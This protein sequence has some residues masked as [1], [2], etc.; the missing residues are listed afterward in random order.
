MKP[1][2]L[3]P[4]DLAHAP[5]PA[6]RHEHALL[7]VVERGRQASVQHRQD[8]ARRVRTLPDR[9]LGRGRPSASPCPGSTIDRAITQRP[10]PFE[11]GHGERRVEAGQPSASSAPSTPASNPVQVRGVAHC[12]DHRRG[13][14]DLAVVELNQIGLDASQAPTEVARTP[15][16]TSFFVF[17]PAEAIAELRQDMRPAVDEDDIRLREV[18]EGPMRGPQQV[19]ELGGNFDAGRPAAH[20]DEREER[21]AA[22]QFRLVGRFL[23]LGQGAV[24]EVERVAER[25]H[26]DRVLGHAGPTPESR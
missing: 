7:A 6:E 24:P 19:L 17:V 18:G 22:G 12:A 10:H 9:V 20:D 26:A 2:T 3:M 11:P 4:L 8:V 15:A 21:I 25:P 23:E 5:E 1:E 16:R 13:R 14:D